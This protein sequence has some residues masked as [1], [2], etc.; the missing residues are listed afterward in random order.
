MLAAPLGA[1][2]VFGPR[3]GQFRV[4]HRVLNAAVAKVGLEGGRVV[5]CTDYRRGQSINCGDL[6]SYFCG[7]RHLD[8]EAVW[9]KNEDLPDQTE[10]K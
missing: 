8:T 1:P 10:K 4:P 7:P 6:R 2:K 9:G 5:D 3:R